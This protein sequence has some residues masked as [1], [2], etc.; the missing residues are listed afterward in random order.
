MGDAEPLEVTIDKIFA[1]VVKKYNV[2]RE[3][4]T[5][6]KRAKEIM[7]P[8]HISIYLIREITELSLPRIGK[9]FDRDH[10]TMLSSC[11]WVQKKI[12]HD[13]LFAAD[14][15]LLRKEISGN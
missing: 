9:I 8:R 13:P 5:G 15:E 11:E 7:T 6:K 4:I 12:I 3:E 10:S 2:P 14:L 1:A